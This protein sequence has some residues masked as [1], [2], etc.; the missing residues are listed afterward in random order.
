MKQAMKRSEKRTVKRTWKQKICLLLV[1]ALCVSLCGCFL[2]PAENLYAVPQQSASFYNLNSAIESV[3]SGD[4]AYCPPLGGENQ[5]AVQMA[6]LDGDK[7][8]EAIVYL[9]IGGDKPLC[10]CV[11]DRTGDSYSLLARIDGVGNS[12]DQVQYIPFDDRSGNEIVVGRRL[13]DG[14]T[15]VLSVLTL[16]DGTLVELINAPYYEFMTTDLNADTL[17]DVVLLHQEA[18]AQN[19]VAVFY[20]WSDGQPVRDLE[21]GLSAPVSAVKRIISGRMCEGVPAVFVASAYGEGKIVTDI[22]GLRQNAFVNLTISDDTDTGV[23][24][25]RDY[26]VYS[27]D[28]DADGYIEL[29]RL[30]PMPAQKDEE[31]SSNQSLIRWYNLLLSG[32]EQEKSLTYHNYSDGWYLTVSDDWIDKVAVK[33]FSDFG[34]ARGYCFVDAKSGQTI[35]NILALSTGS[36]RSDGW[37]ELL[38]KGETT[39][40]CQL[41]EAAQRYGIDETA[42]RKMFRLI[43]VDWNTGET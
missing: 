23:Q 40:I 9:K 28:I 8:D 43:R 42:V 2:D 7:N 15:Q 18:E 4:T 20:H 12:F 33:N 26:Y 24:T 37:L 35:F 38:Q 6:D 32:R 1:L 22:F 41:G 29:P 27:A 5:Q 25:V 16:Q 10:L 19:G 13:S 30:I 3:L 11:F 31:S 34:S 36:V 17:R 14:V 39:Y 21:A